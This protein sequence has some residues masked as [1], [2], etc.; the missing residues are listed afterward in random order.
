MQVTT[1]ADKNGNI[2]VIAVPL[3]IRSKVDTT[4][5]F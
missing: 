1:F 5:E 4:V 2:V 3:A